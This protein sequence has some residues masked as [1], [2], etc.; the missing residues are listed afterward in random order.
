MYPA[1]SSCSRR[2]VRIDEPATIQPEVSQ[3][4]VTVRRAM[5][6]PSGH[7]PSVILAADHF[8]VRRNASMSTTTS[9]AL[10]VGWRF[11]ALDLSCNPRS[12]YLRYRLTP[13]RGAPPRDPHFSSDMRNRT[14]ATPLYEASSSPTVSGALPCVTALILLDRERPCRNSHSRADDQPV[15]FSPASATSIPTTIRRRRTQRYA[16]IRGWLLFRV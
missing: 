2:S 13:L 4:F 11:G 15:Y 8:R 1:R 12:P 7:N 9:A 6:M 16:S 3:D 14:S 5:T 10:A